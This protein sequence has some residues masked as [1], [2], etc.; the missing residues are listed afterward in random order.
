M[1]YCKFCFDTI[2]DDQ[3]FCEVCKKV[4]DL[5]GIDIEEVVEFNHEGYLNHGDRDFDSFFYDGWD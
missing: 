2:D 1:K 3:E 4:I 5:E